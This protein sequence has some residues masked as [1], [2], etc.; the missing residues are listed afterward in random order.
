MR[1]RAVALRW[2]RADAAAYAASV[3]ENALQRLS[4]DARESAFVRCD[5]IL[6][7][8][9]TW[10]F[11]Q[12]TSSTAGPVTVGGGSTRKRDSGGAGRE[13]V[14]ELVREVRKEMAASTSGGAGSGGGKEET[15]EL[16]FEV[17]AT[18]LEIFGRM[19]S[20][21]RRLFLCRLRLIWDKRP[22]HLRTETWTDGQL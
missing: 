22:Q 3:L 12:M 13:S 14:Q 21:V 15:E 1:I 19:D 18:V 2:Y 4:Y 7:E 20:L 9:S 11:G 6:A 16:C 8:F 5:D 10:P 17:I